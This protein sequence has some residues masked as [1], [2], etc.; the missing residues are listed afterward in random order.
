MGEMSWT[1]SPLL[2]QVSA[3]EF[4]SLYS[5]LATTLVMTGS[6]AL[7]MFISDLPLRSQR[8]CGERRRRFTA[9]VR[10]RGS[11]KSILPAASRGTAG[12]D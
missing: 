1:H 8:V 12:V 4:Y 2:L 11:F 5:L 6:L 7:A 9:F 10:R 3:H